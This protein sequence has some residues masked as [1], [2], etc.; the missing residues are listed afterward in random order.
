MAENLNFHKV[1]EPEKNP[2]DDFHPDTP[3]DKELKERVR[4]TVRKQ[5][6]ELYGQGQHYNDPRCARV[7]CHCGER[8]PLF[9]AYKCF[10][11][12]AWLCKECAEVHFATEED[13]E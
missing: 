5:L 6:T 7:T 10:F 1:E 3:E 9:A 11:C 2:R 8:V 13:E 4:A 12:K